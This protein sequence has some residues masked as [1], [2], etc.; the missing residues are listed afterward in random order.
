[1]IIRLLVTCHLWS[2]T[3]V[4]SC[5]LIPTVT[6]RPVRNCTGRTDSVMSIAQ[7]SKKRLASPCDDRDKRVPFVIATT[8]IQCYD[9]LSTAATLHGNGRVR[10]IKTSK[11]GPWQEML[12]ANRNIETKTVPCGTF[13]DWRPI[14]RRMGWILAAN[15]VRHS[16]G[17]VLSGQSVPRLV[18][19]K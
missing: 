3:D 7:I 9:I 2:W 4:S 6:S 12:R 11:R 19:I 10:P 13:I 15:R 16:I 8:V 14:R 18:M 1:M 5:A 17:T